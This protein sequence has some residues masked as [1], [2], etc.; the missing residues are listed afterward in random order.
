M[1]PDWSAAYSANSGQQ[2][3]VIRVQLNGHRTQSSQEYAIKLRHKWNSDPRCMYTN[4]RGQQKPLDVS[5]DTG[6]MVSTALNFGANS[7]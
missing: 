4:R 2:D 1:D 7:P 3:T 5:F 6:G